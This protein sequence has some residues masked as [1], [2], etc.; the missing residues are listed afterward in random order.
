M[1]SLEN[2]FF[3]LLVVHLMYYSLKLSLEILGV[4]GFRNKITA[5]FDYV[6]NYFRPPTNHRNNENVEQVEADVTREDL[7]ALT[8]PGQEHVD[9]FLTQ[10]RTPP[11]TI[12]DIPRFCQG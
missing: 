9:R 11:T 12:Q 8:T 4:V 2:V 7:E 6:Y 5:M 1:A 10:Q 3:I